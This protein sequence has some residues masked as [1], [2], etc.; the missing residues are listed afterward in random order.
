MENIRKWALENINF[1]IPSPDD[2]YYEEFI[3]KYSEDVNYY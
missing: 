3:L 2:K 1:R